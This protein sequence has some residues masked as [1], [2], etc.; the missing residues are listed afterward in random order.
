MRRQLPDVYQQLLLHVGGT[1]ILKRY[2]G[3]RAY[4]QYVQTILDSFF[5]AAERAKMCAELI[6]EPLFRGDPG[7]YPF[8]VQAKAELRCQELISMIEET[9]GIRVKLRSVN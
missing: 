1:D 6:D 4:W 9:A 3:S 2:S 7:F 5:T 8:L